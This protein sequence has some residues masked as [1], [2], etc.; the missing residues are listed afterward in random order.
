MVLTQ[1]CKLSFGTVPDLL[2]P[3]ICVSFIVDS[4][5]VSASPRTRRLVTNVLDQEG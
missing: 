4:F 5:E 1:S 2:T 3:D